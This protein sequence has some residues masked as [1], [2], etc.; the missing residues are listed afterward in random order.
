MVWTDKH[1]KKL[2]MMLLGLDTPVSR[3]QFVGM[4]AKMG[5]GINDEHCR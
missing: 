1:D 4:G 5:E 2:L 3:A